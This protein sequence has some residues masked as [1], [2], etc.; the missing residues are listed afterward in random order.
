MSFQ[1][2]FGYSCDDGGKYYWYLQVFVQIVM[3]D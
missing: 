3:M 1:Y 2:V